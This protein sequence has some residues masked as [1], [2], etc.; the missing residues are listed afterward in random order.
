MRRLLSSYA[1]YF[2]RRHRRVGHLFQNRFKSLLVDAD[3]DLLELVRSVHLNPIRCGLVAT[4][5]ALE[6]YPWTGHQALSAGVVNA[7]DRRERG[8]SS[9]MAG[10][11]WGSEEAA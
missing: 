9:A 7:A 1:G 6:D 10:R 2:N 11:G 5:D 4:L 3:E 8:S